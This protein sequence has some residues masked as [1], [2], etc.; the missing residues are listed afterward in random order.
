M[1]INNTNPD[2][3]PGTANEKRGTDLFHE[4]SRRVEQIIYNKFKLERQQQEWLERHRQNY[5][6]LRRLYGLD[7][8]PSIDRDQ[9]GD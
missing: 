6:E 9:S 8:F 4:L 7:R 1:E 3:N 5:E 2:H